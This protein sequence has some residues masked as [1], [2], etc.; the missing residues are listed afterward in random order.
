MKTTLLISALTA[1]GLQQ[2]TANVTAVDIG[3]A[4]PPTTLGGYTM[5]AFD[6]GSITG[7]T[8][9]Q[10]PTTWATWGQGYTGDVYFTYGTT[11]T[12]T[13]SGSSEAVYFYEEPNLFSTF[14]MTA[15]DSSGATVTQAINGDAGAAGVGFYETTSGGPYLTQI[16]ITTDAAAEGEA[17]GEFGISGGSLA[18]QTGV[19]VSAPDGGAT[20]TLLGL[21]LCGTL[22]YSRF[23]RVTA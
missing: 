4:A 15:T 8:Q 3:T 12:L 11:I 1:L 9:A 19:P 2:V 14:N 21:A 10:V 20:L 6:P 22:A 18:G 17:I 13:L 16:V 23:N 7:A 5:S